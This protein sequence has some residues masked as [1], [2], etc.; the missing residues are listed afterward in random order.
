MKSTFVAE[1]NTHT[2]PETVEPLQGGGYTFN[3][4]RSL[5]TTKQLMETLE[6]LEWVD[7]RTRAVF[8]EFTLYNANVNLF[9]SCIMLVEFISSGA[10]VTRSE[11]KVSVVT[12]RGSRSVVVGS[13]SKKTSFY[14]KD[15]LVMLV[16]HTVN[17]ADC[18]RCIYQQFM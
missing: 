18:V 9:A 4:R 14:W 13:N 8:I 1:C 3:F 12:S 7:T 15:C 10:A 6:R 11:V 2:V 5:K 16:K 17:C